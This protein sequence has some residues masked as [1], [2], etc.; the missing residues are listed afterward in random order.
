MSSVHMTR[1]TTAAPFIAGARL[2][3]HFRP[4]VVAVFARDTKVSNFRGSQSTEL[5][6]QATTSF[7]SAGRRGILNARIQPT[8]ARQWNVM[9]DSSLCDLC[10]YCQ[11]RMTETLSNSG[12]VKVEESHMH[13]RATLA[14]R[15]RVPTTDSVRAARASILLRLLATS[16]FRANDLDA[17]ERRF[18][19]Y[20][21]QSDIRFS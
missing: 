15:M 18:N 20:R 13:G 11:C 7:A 9:L 16:A 19:Q 3:R 14:C 12:K 4:F 6:H 8:P 2:Y 1:V 21:T 5:T 17:G 10:R